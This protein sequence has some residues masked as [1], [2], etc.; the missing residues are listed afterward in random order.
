MTSQQ[1]Q[2]CNRRCRR[3]VSKKKS[4]Q[5]L[6]FF[7]ETFY[8]FGG[9]FFD[10]FLYENPVSDTSFLLCTEGCGQRCGCGLMSVR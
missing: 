6:E 2:F 3:K 8:F 9:T 7:P 5:R 10:A 1:I 4:F